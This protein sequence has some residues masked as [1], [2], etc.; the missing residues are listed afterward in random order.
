MYKLNFLF[1]MNL[2]KYCIV[3]FLITFFTGKELYANV[4]VTALFSDHM[5]IQRR[6][7]MK[8]WGESAAGEE[9][10]VHFH[11]I[12]LSS[13]ADSN[14][15]WQVLLPP[16]EHGGP[17]EMV[18]EGDNK[19]VFKDILIGD[20]WLCSGQSNMQWELHRAINPEKEVAEANY[21]NIRLFQVGFGINGKP[22]S[23]LA[24]GAWKICNPENAKDFSAVAYFFGRHLHKN[25][26]IPIG[27][28]Q[29]AVGGSIIET[30]SSEASL[31]KFPRFQ[32]PFEELRLLNVA[33]IAE[34]TDKLDDAWNDTLDKFEPGIAANW[35]LPE[36]NTTDWQ[37][38]KI[39]YD[40]DVIEGVGVGWFRKE[41]EL[42]ENE[43]NSNIVISLGGIYLKDETYLNGTKIGSSGRY[44]IKR[45]YG[46]CSGILKKGKNVL[47]VRVKNTWGAH[48]FYGKAENLF[49][50]TATQK[51]PLSGDWQFMKGRLSKKPYPSIGHNDYPSLRYNSMLSP[52]HNYA[53][54]GV[55]WYQGETNA[56][57]SKPYEYRELL[58]NL[59][60]DWRKQWA[61]GNFP[62]LIVQ[63]PNFF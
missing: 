27:L 49:C 51:I 59:I 30:W 14:G 62:F 19:I 2:I 34:K 44:E 60:E 7:P 26:T 39:P 33:E 47:V 9:I 54:K 55:I 41:F 22:Q 6:Q 42:T 29:S 15:N 17:F 11:E 57:K 31:Q 50:L 48:G 12:K 3:F 23:T 10:Q 36:T 35:H 5:V 24:S 63:L 8:V 28:I 13:I 58:P 43:V 46:A 37:S 40:W 45:L 18:I 61:I 32:K 4:T 20:V 52:L 53:I 1:A 25:L 56:S 21:N 38:I 16:F